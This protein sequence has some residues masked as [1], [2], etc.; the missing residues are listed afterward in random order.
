MIVDIGL[1]RPRIGVGSKA[2]NIN[3]AVKYL[4]S[5]AG[6]VSTAKG[7]LAVRRALEAGGAII[8][9]HAGRTGLPKN[10]T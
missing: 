2:V 1:A 10:E 6:E 7:A 3:A 8:N 4:D 5:H 9:P